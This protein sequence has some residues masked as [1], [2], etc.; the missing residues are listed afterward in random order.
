M[1]NKTP[2]FALMDMTI[3]KF[4]EKLQRISPDK[5]KLPLVVDCPNGMEVDPQIKMRWDD[6]FGQNSGVL[7]GKPPTKMVITWQ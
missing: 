2:I 5:R 4:I 3:D 1:W 6:P 7:S